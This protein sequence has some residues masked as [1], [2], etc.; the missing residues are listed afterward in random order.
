MSQDPAANPRQNPK[1]IRLSHRI[2]R[3][4]DALGNL[5]QPDIHTGTR[6]RPSAFWETA[7]TNT[8]LEIEG[9][10]GA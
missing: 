10:P 9:T 1:S 3:T 5:H 2:V 8:L 4:P 6:R 7:Y